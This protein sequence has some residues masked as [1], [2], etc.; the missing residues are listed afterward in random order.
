MVEIAGWSV[1]IAEFSISQIHPALS[2]H[3]IL[4]FE[5]DALVYVSLEGGYRTFHET[6]IKR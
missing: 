4:A 2:P 5:V 3:A 1:G 6:V